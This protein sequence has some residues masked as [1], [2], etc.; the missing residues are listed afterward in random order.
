MALPFQPG[1][2]QFQQFPGF[3]DLPIRV[4]RLERQF[5]VLERAVDQLN[6]E[7]NRIERRLERCCPRF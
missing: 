6:R 1:Q 2:D 5:Q 3:F 7:V 4:A